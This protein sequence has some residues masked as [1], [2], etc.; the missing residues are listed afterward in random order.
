MKLLGNN[1]DYVIF[2]I[3]VLI[4]AVI[5][6]RVLRYIIGEGVNGAS[7]KLKI[8]DQTQF[9]FLKNAVE[10]IVY[11]IAFIVIFDS[12]PQLKNYGTALFAGAGVIA[13]I[14]GF[15]SQ[16]A[17]SNIV[18]GI[19]IVM[20]K[21]FSV[22]DRVRI[23]QLYQ[24]DVEDITLRHTIIKDFENRRIVIPNSVMNNETIINSTLTEEKVRMFIEIGITYE[25]NVDHAVEI[26]RDEALKHPECI[27]NRTAEERSNDKP[28]VEV[29]LISFADSAQQLRAYVW[30]KNPSSGFN[31]KCD[32]LKSIKH[33]FDIE[34]I[35]IAYPHRIVYL[36]ETPTA[37][38][39]L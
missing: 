19:F 35:E 36:R 3:I 26:M 39:V 1:W 18:S 5:V 12:I 38:K 34:G 32:L 16:S 8:V 17:F 13:A 11:I 30:A 23:G 21:P 7:R 28:Q 15:A 29:L 14:V 37:D 9:N 22:G 4:I 27:D 25:S 33:R 24:G 10:F 6:G 2:A 31:M 20:F